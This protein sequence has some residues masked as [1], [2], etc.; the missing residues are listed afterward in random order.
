MQGMERAYQQLI[1]EYLGYFP[2]VVIVGA[3]QTGKSTLIAKVSDN[4]PIF[5]LEVR[6]DYDQIARDPD[7]FLR[8]NDKP[9]AIDEAQRLPDI[10]T[11]LRVAIDR[12]RTASGKYLLSG[13]SS[14]ELL[15]AIS[16]SLAGRVGII[17]IA[18]FSFTETRSAN[19]P[20]LTTR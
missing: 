14:P 13:S 18:P 20:N 7:F 17:E 4:R 16:E 5:D 15:S 19:T 1:I 2:C 12:D 11:A 8:A 6:A 10:F 3:R 9:I